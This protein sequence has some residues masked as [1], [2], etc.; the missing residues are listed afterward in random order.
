MTDNSAEK[1]AARRYQADHPDLTYPEALRRVRELRRLRD[2]EAAEP[3]DPAEF[4]PTIQEILEAAVDGDDQLVGMSLSVDH[5]GGAFDVDLGPEIEGGPV[6]V[7]AVDIHTDTLWFDEHEQY[8]DGTLLGEAHVT[9]TITYSACVYKSTYY[10][11][12]D[13]VGWHVADP[14][15]NDH[16]IL[17]RGEFTGELVYH[18]TIIDGYDRTEGLTLEELIQVDSGSALSAKSQ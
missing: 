11:A 15:W 4:A 3:Y 17:V 12:P 14:D 6:D 9:A 7:E 13:S 5:S 2:A 8:E 16:Y 1:R 18:F 10:S